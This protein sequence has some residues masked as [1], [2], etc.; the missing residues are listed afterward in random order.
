MVVAHPRVVF[1]RTSTIDPGGVT[2]PSVKRIAAAA[3]LLAIVVLQ[4]P[5]R[6]V[7]GLQYFGYW[8]DSDISNY[9]CQIQDHAN[10]T[11]TDGDGTQ[12]MTNYAAT[13]GV[14]NWGLAAPSGGGPAPLGAALL[15]DD[16]DSHAWNWCAEHPCPNG[17]A[18]GWNGV[19]AEIEASYN[20]VQQAHPGQTVHGYINLADGDGNG[21]LDFRQLPNFSL[22]NG[23]DW[24][25]LE[26]YM[27]AAGCL[28]NLNALKSTLNLPPGTNVRFWILTPAS[29]TGSTANEAALVT[30]AWDTYNWAKDD[31]LVIGMLAFVWSKTMLCPPDCDTYGVKEMPNL[32]A[33]YRQIGDL[34]T[35]RGG[36][37]PIAGS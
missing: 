26:C 17:I 25:G 31:P 33:A 8:R 20:Q 37:Q 3:A 12:A 14:S 11:M 30:T 15:L 19:K 9:V 18:D 6:A 24:I 23:V 27:G 4:T 2:M 35:G 5:T 7:T 34:I 22:P 10:V 28:D 1:Q 13:F 21:Q 29:A 36:V 32:L 16:A